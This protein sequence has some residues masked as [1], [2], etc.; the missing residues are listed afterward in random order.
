ME[1]LGNSSSEL[2]Q[3]HIEK[4][5]GKVDKVYHEI[6]S[7]HVHLDVY[8]V[9]PTEEDPYYKLITSGMSDKPMTFPY[10][11]NEGTEQYLEL[12]ITL[13]GDWQL[14][15]HEDQWYWPI[16]VLKGL[17]R[18][19]HEYKTFL[20]NGHTL[21]NGPEYEPYSSSTKLCGSILVPFFGDEP[22]HCELKI[23]D[24]KTI[25]FYSV[26]PLYKEEIEYKMKHGA[27]AFFKK[28]IKNDFELEVIPDRPIYKL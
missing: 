26:L 25:Y 19:P 16:R 28:L 3:E 24:K 17:A 7:E 1:D 22:E 12:M 9:N 15:S 11:V 14:G 18:F 2:I 20:G 6:V 13:P 23:D 4:Y 10:E 5:I 27:D 8:I 21:Q